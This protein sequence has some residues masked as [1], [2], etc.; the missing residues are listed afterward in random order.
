MRGTAAAPTIPPHPVVAFMCRQAL[1][2]CLAGRNIRG[3]S[4]GK[5][6][7]LVDNGNT[8]AISMEQ[9]IAVAETVAAAKILD[10]S[11]DSGAFLLGMMQ[12][13]LALNA[14]LFRAGATPE[15][16]YRQKLNI[17]SRSRHGVDKDASAVS[18]AM[19]RLWLSLAVDYKAKTRRNRCPT[20][21]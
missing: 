1:E 12:E 16:L 15:I 20:W 7:N 6:A 11:C 14:S 2:D 9:A 17:I 5:I 8:A 19:L 18:I 4:D 13:I 21:I 10:P 3:L